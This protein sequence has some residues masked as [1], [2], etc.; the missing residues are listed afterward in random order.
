MSCGSVLLRSATAITTVSAC[1]SIPTY[2]VFFGERFLVSVIGLASFAKSLAERDNHLVYGSRSER[3]T[4]VA[5]LMYSLLESAE[6]AG[7]N[8]EMYLDTAVQAALNGEVVPLPH[9]LALESTGGAT[10]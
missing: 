7:V 1:T 8:P 6:L 5:A 2:R 3:G 10:S 4:E 9:E